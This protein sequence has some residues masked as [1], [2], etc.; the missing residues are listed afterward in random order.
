MLQGLKIADR[1]GFSWYDDVPSYI[2][3]SKYF[4]RFVNSIDDVDTLENI[5]K[6]DRWGTDKHGR[7]I[8]QILKGDART[9][10]DNIADTWSKTPQRLADGGLLIKSNGNVVTFYNST[11]GSGLPTIMINKSGNISKIRFGR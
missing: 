9:V 5:A 4:A 10:F 8:Y 3:S 2:T 11:G 6:M 7:P 1:L